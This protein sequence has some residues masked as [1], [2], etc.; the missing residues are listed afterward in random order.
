[1]SFVK[2]TP[3]VIWGASGHARVVADAVR[4]Q[5]QFAVFGFIDNINQER[6]GSPFCGST[7]LGGIEVLDE[8]SS[9]GVRHLIMA[10]GDCR[11]RLELAQLAQAH[12]FE[13]ATIIHPAAVVARDVMM[14]SGTVIVAGAVINPG[15]VIGENVI[16]NTLASVDHDCVIANGVHIC[17]GVH[18]AGNVQVGEATWVGIGSVVIEHVKIGAYSLIGAGS[19]VAADIPSN[20]MAYGVPARVVKE[21]NR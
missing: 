17:P 8:L 16:I 4:L 15:A 12:H 19:V 1:M 9:R 7:I 18:L 20:V 21:M 3:L 11:A 10:F 14:G 2:T 5:N 6:K 13:L